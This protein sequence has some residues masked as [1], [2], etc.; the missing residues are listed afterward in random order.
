[1]LELSQHKPAQ[2]CTVFQAAGQK[3]LGDNRPINVSLSTSLRLP[4]EVS[5]VL[6]TCR[7]PEACKFQMI[8][9]LP[10]LAFPL[11]PA[12]VFLL[13]RPLR[14][15]AGRWLETIRWVSVQERQE[16]QTKIGQSFELGGS[17]G[18]SRNVAQHAY[19]E[20]SLPDIYLRQ[21]RKVGIDLFT[22]PASPGQAWALQAT[23]GK[24]MT[25]LYRGT[26][27]EAQGNVPRFCAPGLAG[28]VMELQKW[29]Q[30]LKPLPHA[31]YCALYPQANTDDGAAL[32]LKALL[33]REVPFQP[34]PPG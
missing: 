3:S 11:G 29:G 7:Y 21:T 13:D 22:P 14:S 20:E 4:P 24:T 12:P 6:Y 1:M 17:S 26:R 2:A 28:T 18:V 15:R 33:A 10:S 31:V 5:Q 30:A 9:N 19:R 16:Q 27:E 34:P 8:G 25:I 32:Y 23:K